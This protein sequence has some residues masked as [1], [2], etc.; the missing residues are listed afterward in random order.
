LFYGAAGL[1]Y[2]A[3][4]RPR[5]G[6]RATARVAPTHTGGKYG[7][8]ATARAAPTHTGGKYGDRAAPTHKIRQKKTGTQP[9]FTIDK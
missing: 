1:F 7:D 6:D 2:G 8:R 3:A 5:Y 4:G 9:V